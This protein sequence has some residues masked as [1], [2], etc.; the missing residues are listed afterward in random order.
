MIKATVTD[1]KRI[2]EKNNFYKQLPI[3]KVVA[4]NSLRKN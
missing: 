4:P 2:N 1:F 3:D